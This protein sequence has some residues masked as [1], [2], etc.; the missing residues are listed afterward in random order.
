MDHA[1]G[2]GPF[3]P[4]WWAAGGA[5]RYFYAKLFKNLDM[6]FIYNNHT[7]VYILNLVH[8]CTKIGQNPLI[9]TLLSHNDTVLEY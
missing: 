9:N 6:S 3:E 8:A 7:T 1:G 4:V 2:P 5:S